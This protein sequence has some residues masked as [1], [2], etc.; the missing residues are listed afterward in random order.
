MKLVNSDRQTTIPAKS[1]KNINILLFPLN[2]FGAKCIFNQITI[3]LYLNK[4]SVY[5]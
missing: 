4:A 5:A 3:S 2:F 1:A